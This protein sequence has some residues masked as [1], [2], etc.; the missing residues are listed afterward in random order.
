MFVFS[1]WSI[2]TL[3]RCSHHCMSYSNSS[4]REIRRIS[5][6]RFL[7]KKRR[8]RAFNESTCARLHQHDEIRGC[9]EFISV[10]THSVTRLLVD[11]DRSHNDS[12]LQIVFTSGISTS[13]AA[14]CLPIMTVIRFFSF[15]LFSKSRLILRWISLPREESECRTVHEDAHG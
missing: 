2:T 1:I 4:R 10:D 8:T 15:G 7:S 6:R 13:Y 5:G 12:A 9:S 3:D 14:D 11:E